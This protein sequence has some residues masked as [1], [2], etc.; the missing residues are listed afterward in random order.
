MK[1]LESKESQIVTLN[2]INKNIDLHEK[3]NLSNEVKSKKINSIK[4]LIFSMILNF[5]ANENIN[6]KKNFAEK[7]EFISTLNLLE[8]EVKYIKISLINFKYK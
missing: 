5:L 4:I 6:E 8:K 2:S 3:N 7:N 1:V